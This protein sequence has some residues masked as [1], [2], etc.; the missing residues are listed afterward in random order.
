[1]ESETIDIVY[2]IVDGD[3][4]DPFVWWQVVTILIT[5]KALIALALVTQYHVKR[6]SSGKKKA[7]LNFTI[8]FKTD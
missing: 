4:C 6:R 3:C 8:V 7:S 2:T 5:S 1:M